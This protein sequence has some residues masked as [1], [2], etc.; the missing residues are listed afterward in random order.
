MWRD[1][2]FP[3]LQVLA[4]RGGEHGAATRRGC[5]VF[6]DP[7]TGVS[8]GALPSAGAGRGS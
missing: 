7:C 1:L 8:H 3:E 2:L 6:T 5:A 4:A